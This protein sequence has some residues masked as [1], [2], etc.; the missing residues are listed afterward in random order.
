MQDSRFIKFGFDLRVV[1]AILAVSLA[2]GIANN[3]R[4]DDER[5]VPWSGAGIEPADENE[6]ETSEDEGKKA[7]EDD[8]ESEGESDEDDDDEDDGEDGE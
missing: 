5:R 8:M 2:A 6:F 3:L 1:A 4:V 7:E